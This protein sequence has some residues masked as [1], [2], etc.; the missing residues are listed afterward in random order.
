MLCFAHPSA[1]VSVCPRVLPC[2]RAST[3]RVQ[4]SNLLTD[5]TSWFGRR[6]PWRPRQGVDHPRPQ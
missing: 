5:S 4:E 6:G 1:Q 3:Q 2:W